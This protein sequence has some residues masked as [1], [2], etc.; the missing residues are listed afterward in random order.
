[1]QTIKVQISLWTCELSCVCMCMLYSVLCLFVGWW[2]RKAIDFYTL[3]ACIIHVNAVHKLFNSMC[4]QRYLHRDTQ[5]HT[6]N[7]YICFY[8]PREILVLSFPIASTKRVGFRPH[9]I[10]VLSLQYLNLLRVKRNRLFFTQFLCLFS[11]FN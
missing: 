9:F 1:M 6:I 4:A 7:I 8:L 2:V 3:S 11:N 10:N 5:I